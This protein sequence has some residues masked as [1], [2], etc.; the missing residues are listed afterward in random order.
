MQLSAL[1]V[2]LGGIGRAQAEWQVVANNVEGK[3]N[4]TQK[5]AIP[6]I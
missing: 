6:R 2:L 5:S 3:P 4:L 1:V